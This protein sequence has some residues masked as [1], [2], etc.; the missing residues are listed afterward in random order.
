MRIL[1]VSFFY[2]PSR[3]GIESA[4]ATLAEALAGCGNDV[5]VATATPGRAGRRR[6]GRGS[7][8]V[9]RRPGLLVVLAQA[10]RSRVVIHSTICLRL[11]ALVPLLPVRQLLWLHNRRSPGLPQL[12]FALRCRRAAVSRTLAA[13][14]PRPVDRLPNP[15]DPLFLEPATGERDH[16]VLFVGRLETV[17]GLD[18][19]LRALGFGLAGLTVI[20]DGPQRDALV[21][22]A[23]ALGLGGRIR[24]LGAQPIAAVAAEMRR[25]RVLAVPSRDE[26]FGLSAREGLACGCRVVASDVGALR[27]TLGDAAVFVPANDPAA[28]AE[29]LRT[30]L[31]LTTPR[32]PVVNAD[33]SPAAVARR[34]LALLG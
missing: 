5:V 34:A 11:A 24:W 27:E 23:G 2:P 4:T 20:G 12:L 30:A 15:L 8:T 28:L 21:A 26:T 1:V 13:D 6:Y 29:A 33:F 16:E 22:L 17:K 19:L 32:Q 14:W 31:T 9:L 7:V 3:G 10:L 18:V 25:H